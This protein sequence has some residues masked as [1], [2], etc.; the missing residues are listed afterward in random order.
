V[1]R[2]D[3]DALDDDFAFLGQELQDFTGFAFVFAGENDNLVA[4]FDFKFSGHD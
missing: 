4:F 3:V 1:F 2:L